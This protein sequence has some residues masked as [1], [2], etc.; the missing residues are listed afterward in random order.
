M[1]L[2]RKLN[3][4]S[5][6]NNINIYRPTFST[7]IECDTNMYSLE[8]LPPPTFNTYP[9]AVKHIENLKIDLW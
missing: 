5:K 2:H 9:E 3:L 4:F 1:I 7:N 8:N 6:Y